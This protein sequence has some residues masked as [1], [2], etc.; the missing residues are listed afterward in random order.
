M[1]KVNKLAEDPFQIFKEDENEE[2]LKKVHFGEIK[3]TR[4]LDEAITKIST[5]LILGFGEAGSNIVSHS[6]SQFGEL[7]PMLPGK[8]ITAIFGFCDILQF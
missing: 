5:L 1:E 8:K 2:H 6:L 3:E 4:L 7:D